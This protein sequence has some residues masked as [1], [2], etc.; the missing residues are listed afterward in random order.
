MKITLYNSRGEFRVIWLYVPAVL[1]YGILANLYTPILEVVWDM[2][3]Y[4]SLAFGLHHPSTFH[5]KD[6]FPMPPLYPLI[7]SL[8]CFAPTYLWI[9]AAQSWINPL[10]YFLGLYPLYR[11]SR[12]WLDPHRSALACFFYALYPSAIYTQW[13]MSENLAAPLV[14]WVAALSV[15]ILTDKRPST[16][17]GAWLGVA[18]A[19]LA[20]TRIQVIVIGAGALGWLAYRTL[21]RRRDPAP[22]L[23][24]ISLSLT[25]LITVWWQM[26]YLTHPYSSPVYARFNSQNHASPL[27]LF[28]TLFSTHWTG[29]WLEGGAWITSLFLAQ[30]IVALVRPSWLT[31]AQ[32]EAFRMLFFLC[33][34]LIA[35]V[36][37][38]YVRRTEYEAWS[39]SLRYVFYANLMALPV[40]LSTLGIWKEMNGSRRILYAGLTILSAALLTAGFLLPDG[41]AGFAKVRDFFTNAPSLDFLEQIIQ[42]G[43]WRTGAFFL[44][45]SVT[46][47]LTAFAR[48]R[49]GAL[50]LL[51]L[52]AYVQI[53][54]IDFTLEIRQ[55]AIR[56][57]WMNEIHDFCEQLEEGKWTGIPIYCEEN[58]PHLVPNLS[59]WVNRSS[60]MLPPGSPRPREEHLLLTVQRH[61]DGMLLFR[62]GELRA[63]LFPAEEKE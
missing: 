27:M 8:G 2:V 46:A 22:V 55:K 63:Y 7:L 4:K 32:K 14:L 60:T 21:K 49:L 10:L 17:T 26:G 38:Y 15:Q 52:L 54:T 24:A 41:W 19:A 39:I 23:M 62:S 35:S 37:M 11:L 36:A 30:Y 61:D 42:E 5:L 43:P 25:W 48:Q 16:V 34:A 6:H 20:L 59:Y 58:T 57:L 28:T 1:V 51:L 44:G 47:G 9:E 53:T 33:V 56:N 29:L 3:F 40:S 31:P 45:L 13:S 50:V 18:A 12:T